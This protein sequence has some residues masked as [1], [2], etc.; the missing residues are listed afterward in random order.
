MCIIMKPKVISRFVSLLLALSLFLTLFPCMAFAEGTTS[1]VSTRQPTFEDILAGNVTPEE[2]ELFFNNQNVATTYNVS[3]TSYI[4]NDTYYINNS[5]CGKYLSYSSS[6]AT[7]ASGLMSSLGNSIL[8]EVSSI[9]GGYVIRSKSDSTKYL[10]V[11]SS[12]SNSGVSIV[13]VSSG[14]SVPSRCIWTISTASNGGTLIKNTY[15]SRYL[16]SLG[17]A[18]A[19]ASSTGTVGSV[20]YDSKVWRI[21]TDSYYGSSGTY[22][23]LTSYTVSNTSICI[24]EPINPTIVKSPSNTLWASAKDFTYSSGDQYQV[25]YRT[26]TITGTQNGSKQV[27]ATHKVTGK[28]ATFTIT[29]DDSMLAASCLEGATYNIRYNAGNNCSGLT[30]GVVWSSSDT[31]VA[32]V[33]SSG[34]VTGGE[35]G[36]AFIYAENLDEEIILACEIKVQSILNQK[37]ANLSSNEI[38]YLYC[39]SSYLSLWTSSLP[40]PFEFKLNVLYCL[41]EYYTKP[42][43]QHPT[44]AELVT[45]LSDFLVIDADSALWLFNECYLGYHGL[46]NSDFLTAQRINYFNYLKEIITF[47]AFSMAANLDPVNSLSNC[48][49]YD[50][51]VYDLSREWGHNESSPN[52]MLGS[53]GHEGKFYYKEAQKYGY[54]YFYSHEYDSVLNK[55]GSEV[56]RSANIRFIQRCLNDNNKFF[57][58]HDPTG[59]PL[60]SSLHME[61]SYLY[62]YYLNEWGVVY[63][64][65]KS[66]LWFFSDTP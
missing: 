17:T 36:Y 37:L 12:T 45:I 63:L 2:F 23:E 43:S 44:G 7:V 61:Y 34:V 21:A 10:G 62:N 13:T 18:L 33:S 35:S 55:Y 28:T 46:Y 40:D 39:P 53:N 16:Y 22:K 50:D 60:N 41:R 47:C 4:S 8:W 56:V 3:A 42:Q 20:D 38:Q 30:N 49:G 31:S 48:N 57:F 19:T 6:S 59:A 58:S 25:D 65:E 5:Y 11:P 54:R 66:G 9:S 15:N 52:V 14:S 51:F 26:G 29:V 32:T 64:K 1:T 27:T 24:G